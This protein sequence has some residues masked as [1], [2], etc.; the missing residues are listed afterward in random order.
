[1]VREQPRFGWTISFVSRFCVSCLSESSA[2]LRPNRKFS[3]SLE[4]IKNK[5]MTRVLNNS[6]CWKFVNSNFRKFVFCHNSEI[7]IIC[8]SEFAKFEYRILKKM[9]YFYRTDADFLSKIFSFYFTQGSA[10][11]I[12]YRS[13]LGK[14]NKNS[15][16]Y[17]LSGMDRTSE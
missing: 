15:F 3:L 2:K 1:M 6:F 17:G 4:N 13:F 9:P 7:R 14:W 16:Y 8:T 5:L 10:S 11:L 12:K